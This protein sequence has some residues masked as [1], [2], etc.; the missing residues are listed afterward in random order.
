M[1]SP[2]VSHLLY[3]APPKLQ[4]SYSAND[5]PNVKGTLGQV[6]NNVHAQHHFHNHNASLGRIPAGA[7]TSR[8]SRELSTDGGASLSGRDGIPYP[9][10]S[11]ALQANGSQ[12]ASFT[13]SQTQVS[14]PTP[15]AIASPVASSQYPSYFP[16]T[17][18][19]HHNGAGPTPY[20]AMPAVLMQNMQSLSLGSAAQAPAYTQ[21]NYAG[22]TPIYQAVPRQQQ[23]SQA[24]VM[25]NRRQMDNEGRSTWASS[26][27]FVLY[28]VTKYLSLPF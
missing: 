25:Q 16:S 21:L 24:R 8:H 23:D 9:S 13:P 26:L 17:G 20:N 3:R 1:V 10:I 5:I 7:M 15:S 18:Y 19:N 6:N 11:A 4:Q 12:S 27:L 14:T 22:Y 28:S 2:S